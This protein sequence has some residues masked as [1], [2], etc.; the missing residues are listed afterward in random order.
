M[1][2][3]SRAQLAGIFAGRITNWSELA[4]KPAP[5]RVFYREETAESL[6]IIRSRLP[7]FATLKFT[8]NGRLLN[9]DFEVIE[10]LERLAWGIGWGSA[11]N[12]RAAKGLR[13][14][15]VDGIV[16]SATTIKS[17]EYPLYFD[18]VLLYK[19]ETLKG[20]AKAFLDFAFSH[21]GRAVTEAFGALPIEPQ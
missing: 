15:S 4:G 20:G 19:R 11:G 6:R 8:A 17:G 5:I 18:A 1:T 9:L 13:V 14:L 3:V 7:E 21:A 10:A 16:P 2:N 12:V